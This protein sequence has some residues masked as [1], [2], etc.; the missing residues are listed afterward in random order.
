[1]SEKIFATN[2]KSVNYL[3]DDKVKNKLNNN[4]NTKSINRKIIKTFNIVKRGIKNNLGK[5]IGFIILFSI[6]IILITVFE[7][8]ID[9]S[10]NENSNSGER[11]LSFLNIIILSI[12]VAGLVSTFNIENTI[13]KDYNDNKDELLCKY[14][15]IIEMLQYNY[16][17]ENIIDNNN[18]KELMLENPNDLFQKINSELKIKNK[19]LE[20]EELNDEDIENIKYIDVSNNSENIIDK[21]LLTYQKDIDNISINDKKDQ[22]KQIKN[23][24]L[25]KIILKYIYDNIQKDRIGIQLYNKIDDLFI[26]LDIDDFSNIHTIKNEIIS[27]INQFLNILNNQ[28]NKLQ[29]NYKQN[30]DTHFKKYY[31]YLSRKNKT[32]TEIDNFKS[33]L[34]NNKLPLT[35][36]YF[37]I[38]IDN[39]NS[40]FIDNIYLKLNDACKYE[41]SCNIK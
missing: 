2:D 17:Q 22:I 23:I 5:F 21:R 9:G 11:F 36:N 37:K 8:P 6:V 13:T 31:F 19:I 15:G 27:T 39:I 12:V 4:F 41:Y 35:Y 38:L 40:T 34:I 26:K 10:Y 32:K 33:F 14:I 20:N 1:M 16:L 30:I 3:F 25:E 7:I 28:K 29:N 18:F 24:M